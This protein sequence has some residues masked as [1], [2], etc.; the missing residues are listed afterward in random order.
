M[1]PHVLIVEDD[2]NVTS[3]LRALFEATGHR[4]S[5]AASVD[6]AIAA[7]V[8]DPP[9]VML[10]DLTLPDGDGLEV[11]SAL[12]RLGVPVPP[13]AALTGHDLPEVAERCRQA[14]CREVLLKPFPPREL[15]AKVAGLAG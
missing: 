10:L 12:A 1:R 2:E 6:E 4:V 8:N 13:T 5:S 15:L 9:A 7:C 3:A 11:L 14:G